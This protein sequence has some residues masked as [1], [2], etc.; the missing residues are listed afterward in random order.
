MEYQ[1]EHSCL[2]WNFSY[3]VRPKS[4]SVATVVSL[5]RN[6]ANPRALTLESLMLCALVWCLFSVTNSASDTRV[7]VVKLEPKAL[8]GSFV[9]DAPSFD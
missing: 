2:P 4:S 1:F 3:Q 7:K 8:I 5:L 6:S 9:K